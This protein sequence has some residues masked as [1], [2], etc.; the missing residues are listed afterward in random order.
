MSEPFI[1]EIRMVGFNF[2][3]RGWAQCAGQLMS[4]A[5]N[6]AL[7]SLLGT[8]Y[9]G[10][11]QTTF[12]LPDLRGRGPV[13]IGQGPGLANITQGELS[14]VE[15][16]TLLNA[17]MPAHSHSVPA[18][19]APVAV[20]GSVA[21][22]ASTESASVPSPVNA[23]PAAGASGGRPFG[24]YNSS[25]SGSDTMAPFNVTLNGSA[26]APAGQTAMAGGGQ[27]VGIRNPSIGIN[28]VI[29]LEG[30]FPSRN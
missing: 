5:Q 3:P 10:N 14:G 8:M 12:G 27:P 21:V 26:S 30:I 1:G 13:G 28:F 16:V 2:A 6:S 9:G 4:I 22:P 24:L 23:V 20:S 18:S 29:A 19:M 17:Q 15:S 7:F 11:G 25:P